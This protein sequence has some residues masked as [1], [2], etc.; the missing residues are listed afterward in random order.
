MPSFD[1]YK[2]L[3]AE[4]GGDLAG[5]LGRRLGS[6]MSGSPSIRRISGWTNCSKAMIA[7]TG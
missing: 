3:H 5:R 7:D 2:L 6:A 4:F 1:P